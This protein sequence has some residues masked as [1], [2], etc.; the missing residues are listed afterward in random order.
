MTLGSRLKELRESK[1]LF[2]REVG[3]I[4]ELDVAYI[5]KIE[6][7]EKLPLKKHIE[8]LSKYYKTPKDELI[9]LWLSD[10]L[11]EVT[12]DEPTSIQSLKLTLKRLKSHEE[13]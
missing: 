7:G 5:S 6:N 12:Q 4:L 10:K 3:A 1:G 11:M 8:K 2:L 9:T 13:K